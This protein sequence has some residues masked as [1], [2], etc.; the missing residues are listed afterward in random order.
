MNL[1]EMGR[2]MKKRSIILKPMKRI[3]FTVHGIDDS[4]FIDMIMREVE[5]LA[6]LDR[7]NIVR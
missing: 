2:L 1:E 6:V 5:Y 4:N 3:T 7:A